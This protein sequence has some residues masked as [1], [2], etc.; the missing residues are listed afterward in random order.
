M[1]LG[2]MY[3]IVSSGGA[4][5]AAGSGG[6]RTLHFFADVLRLNQLLRSSFYSLSESRMV[7]F[8]R[9]GKVFMRSRISTSLRVGSVFVFCG[10]MMPLCSRFAQEACLV[11]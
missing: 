2:D 8:Q 5:W 10:I 1:F 7:S 4:G 9:D 6:L 11:N 3:R